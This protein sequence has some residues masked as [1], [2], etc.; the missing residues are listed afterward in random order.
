MIKL[1][2]KVQLLKSMRDAYRKFVNSVKCKPEHSE[3]PFFYIRNA[4]F[5]ALFNINEEGY[6]LAIVNP[7]QVLAKI[8]KDS[9]YSTLKLHRANLI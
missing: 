2:P 4:N 9:I 8:I 3:M 6:P 5:I 1:M 7:S